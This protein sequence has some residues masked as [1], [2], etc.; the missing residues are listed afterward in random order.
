VLARVQAVVELSAIQP[1]VGRVRLE[2]FQYPVQALGLQRSVQPVLVLKEQVVVRPVLVLVIGALSRLSGLLGPLMET[3]REVAKDMLDLA[4][5]GVQDLVQRFVTE[6][7]TIRSLI[8][9]E[10]DER[11]RRVGRA[12]ESVVVR[13][14]RHYRWSGGRCRYRRSP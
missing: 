12:C 3:K 8:I 2:G 5:V 4:L 9:A 14:G 13:G 7:L 6:T 1:Q 10:L 11:H